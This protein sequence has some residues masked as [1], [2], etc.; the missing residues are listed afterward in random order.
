MECRTWRCAWWRAQ[1]ASASISLAVISGAS[2]Q[3]IGSHELEPNNNYSQRTSLT[4]ST[5]CRWETYLTAMLGA[6]DTRVPDT[7]VCFTGFSQE[8]CT[9]Q[10]DDGGPWASYGGSAVLDQSSAGPFQIRVTGVGNP[11]FGNGVMHG[12]RGKFDVYVDFY[13]AAG[14]YLGTTALH[15]ELVTG[16]ETVLFN[17]VPVMS[18]AATFN[19][20]VNPLAGEQGDVDFFQMSGLRPNAL[21]TVRIIAGVDDRTGFALD[22]VMAEYTASGSQTANFNDDIGLVPNPFPPPDTVIDRRSVLTMTSSATGVIRFAVSGWM[23]LD[24][25]GLNDGSLMRPHPRSGQYTMRIRHNCGAGCADV[26]GDCVV[27]GEDLAA[28][29]SNWGL[30]CP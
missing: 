20:I 29:L 26:N 17:G 9:A 16:T 24:F 22:T 11:G 15:G 10:N 3:V 21:Y 14:N 5:G 1:A 7:M 28:L 8:F 12:E 2:A 27:N 6:T 19:I 25:D 13:N 4:G 23:D 18:G 30:S